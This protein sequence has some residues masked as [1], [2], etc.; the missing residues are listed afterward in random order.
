MKANHLLFFFGCR[1]DVSK[2][3]QRLKQNNSAGLGGGQDHFPVK[4]C[5]RMRCALGTRKPDT[6]LLGE[7]FLDFMHSLQSKKGYVAEE[8]LPRYEA[9]KLWIEEPKI[10]GSRGMLVVRADGQISLPSRRDN[11]DYAKINN[12]PEIAEFVKQ[13]PKDTIIDVEYGTFDADG[14]N[15]TY[16]AR[17]QT[18]SRL[19]S[20]NHWK[21]TNG[22]KTIPL[23]AFAFD[24]L[25]YNGDDVSKVPFLERKDLLKKIVEGINNPH[26]HLIWYV[27]EGF[28]EFYNQQREGVMIKRIDSPYEFG[29]TSHWFKC[30]HFQ[31]QWCDIVGYTEGNGRNQQ[32]WGALVLSV[33][34]KYVGKVGCSN[35]FNDS[36]K[37]RVKEYLL[38][39]KTTPSFELSRQ[40]KEPFTAVTTDLRAQVRYTELT[41]DGILFQPQKIAM[42]GL[43]ESKLLIPSFFIFLG[44]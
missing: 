30:K 9:S 25:R 1:V 34:G 6:A 14:R 11:V 19:G 20:E 2:S 36:E 26:F 33:N 40:V 17:V 41:D 15:D 3:L 44:D 23:H 5:D 31:Y 7:N 8:D 24:I 32:Y 39:N 10:N 37:Q 21:I 27:R 35:G 43:P 29:R 16:E 12:I 18:T 28:R 42:T 22:V 13:L 4:A 38:A